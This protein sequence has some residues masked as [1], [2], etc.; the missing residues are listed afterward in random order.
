MDPLR[1]HYGTQ[2]DPY[3][4]HIDPLWHPNGTLIDPIWNPYP[5][6]TLYAPF[7]PHMDPY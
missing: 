1:I 5:L 3:G 7:G 2:M 6:W 4:T